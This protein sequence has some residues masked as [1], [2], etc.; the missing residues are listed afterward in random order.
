MIDPRRLRLADLIPFVVILCIAAGLRVGYLLNY[1]DNASTDGPV[2]VQDPSPTLVLPEGT[3]MRGQAAV[4]EADALVHN[5]KGHRW[6]GSLAPFAYRE[7]RTAHVAPGYPWLRG[8]LE[9]FMPDNGGADRLIRWLQCVLGT[10]TAGLYYLVARRAFP[11]RTVAVLAGL[12]AAVHPFWVVNTATL[13][14]GVLATFLLAVALWLG[15]RASQVDGAGGSAFA[16]GLALA[17]L[18]LTRAA[19]LPFAVVAVLWLLRRTR[20]VAGGWQFGLV[21]V[22]GLLL[23]L[24]P[25]TIRNIQVFGD[26]FPVIDST[27]LHLWVG[28]NPR[29][30]GGPLTEA[31]MKEAVRP[32]LAKHL[33]SPTIS[34]SA[35]Y[36]LFGPEVA[37][38]IQDDPAG[39]IQR[40]LWAGLYFFFGEDW[41]TR[42]QLW[43]PGPGSAASLDSGPPIP[44][45]L[46]GSLFLMLLLGVLG[47]RWTFIW[48]R[49]AGLL[50]LALM[51][52]PLPYILTHAEALSGPRLPLDG[53]LLVLSAFVLACVAPPLAKSLLRPKRAES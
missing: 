34:Q 47:W 29:A 16:F 5:M 38:Q 45:L 4:T 10:L 3:T 21:A 32:E 51:W 41:F 25:W 40:R 20:S 13:A 18:A 6:F 17:A 39:A 8:E 27:Y 26:I 23:G 2:L 37:R 53:V 15:M 50:A 9:R 35:R 7:E 22:L 48:R 19:L 14:D 43:R 12:L 31:E 46:V 24:A 49:E 42:K 11:G 36:R 33:G 52:I 44:A 28:N 1:A 30:T